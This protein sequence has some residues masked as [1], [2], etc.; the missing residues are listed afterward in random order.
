MAT[1]ANPVLDADWPD[2]DAIRV[3]DDY[4]L[5]ASSFNRA[6]GLPI[7]HSRDLVS[8]TV[9]GHVLRELPPAGHYR[10]PRH[11]GGVWAPSIRHH[12]GRFWI[13]YPD[14]D[15]GIFVLTADDPA[16]IWSEPRLLL[17][18]RGLI[19]PCPLWDDDGRCYLVHAWAKSR[20]GVKNRL[21]VRE[22]DPDLDRVIGPARTVVDGDQIPGYTTLEGPK[23]Y[24]RDGVYWIFAPAGGVTTG[25]QSVFRSPTPY[26]PYEHRVV[27]AQGSTPVN[28]PHQGAWVDTP[29]GEDW[30]LHFSDRGP[31]GRV[32][33]LQPMRWQD[34]WPVIGEAGLEGV[35]QPVLRH[36]RPGS[37]PATTD[38]GEPVVA[39]GEPDRSDPFEGPEL[40]PI[41]HWQANPRPEWYDAPKGGSLR[42]A[43]LPD[44]DGDLRNL[45][46]VLGQ[47]LPGRPTTIT[48]SV[49]LEGG[50]AGA[51]AGL[52]V[53]GRSYAWLG[54]HRTPA[55]VDL[56]LRKREESS[57]DEDLLHQTAL[58]AVP[59]P[60]VELSAEI[61]ED[62]LV[63][64][65]WRPA[66]STRWHKIPTAFTARA[67]QWIGAEVGL[68][69]AAPQGT[70][71]SGGADFGPFCAER[72]DISGTER[73]G[74]TA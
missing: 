65:S 56:V 54:L 62:A 32:V 41:W 58:G 59:E 46:Q 67:G 72:M 3:G 31:V 49:R 25:W 55:G 21:T 18:G 36:R 68:F 53:L 10:I 74:E 4:W 11:G 50:Q 14:P 64:F 33:H 66:G 9:V 45:P 39:A 37:A 7:L 26:G 13:V 29:D 73:D 24:K 51:R 63:R 47:Q 48:T 5:I 16:G 17:A 20:S 12:A 44:D 15:H 19:D 22:V 42:L 61:G 69:A 34:G 71:E 35:G 38:E 2:P 60:C 57:Q 28:G 52:A 8:W 1:Y 23:F 40:A 70:M 27:L 43:V 30:F 6:P